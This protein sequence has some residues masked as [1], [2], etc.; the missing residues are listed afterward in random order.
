VSHE[1][2]VGDL[3]T[4]EKA[5]RPGMQDD[6]WGEVIAVN[7]RHNSIQVVWKHRYLCS[8]IIEWRSP[9]H[10]KPL[11]AVDALS[12]LYLPTIDEI[13]VELERG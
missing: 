7:P 10:L 12:Y 1:F 11:S 5:R 6:I 2:K 3:L 4:W 9:A 8:T 13:L